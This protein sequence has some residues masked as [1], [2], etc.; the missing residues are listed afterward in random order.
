MN[1]RLSLSL[2]LAAL[3]ATLASSCV[4]DGGRSDI[5]NVIP[6]PQ[7]VRLLGG[8]SDAG[9]C[10][11]KDVTDS[12][13]SE[14]EYRLRIKNGILT[15]TASSE[16]GFLY[17]GQ[18]LR[19]LRDSDGMYPDVEIRDWP[20]FRYRGM[21][22]DCARHFF[23]V[24][25]VKRYLDIMALHKL[26]VLHWHLTDDQGWRI[27]IKSWPRLTEVGAWR[28]GDRLGRAGT[29]IGPDDKPYGGFYTQDEL[30]SIVSYAAGLGIDIMPEIDL[31]GHTLAAL[32]SYP[33]LGCT[34]GPY[35]VWAYGGISQDVLCAGSETTFGFIEDVLTEVMDIFPYEYIHIGGDEC[36]KSRWAGCPRCQSRIKELGLVPDGER[37]AEQALQGYVTERVARFLGEHGRR[38]VGW[39]EI[40]E[41]KAPDDAVVMS[42]RG[43]EGGIKASSL[44]HDV[45]MTPNTNLYFDYCQSWD[46][47]TEPEGIGGFIPVWKVY[48]YEPFTPEM[49][50]SRRLRILGVQANLW[51][52][53]ISSDRH[54]EYMLL[55]RLSALS[56]VQWCEPRR[57]SFDRFMKD[58]ARMSSVYDE[59]GFNYARHIFGIIDQPRS[60]DEGVEFTL[61]TAGDGEI[62]YTLGGSDPTEESPLYTAPFIVAERPAVIKAAAFR[63]GGRS[64]VYSK[65]ILANK[66]FRRKVTAL[67]QKAWNYRW[68]P[69]SSL[70]DGLCGGLSFNTADYAA[71]NEEPMD[72]VIDLASQSSSSSSRSLSSS[73]RPASDS[74]SRSLWFDKLT[75][76]SLSSSKRPHPT[77]VPEYSSVTLCVLVDK[78]NYIF[79]PS[80][81]EVSVSDDG[82]SF[83][84]VAS[85]DVETD[86]K[87]APDGL[88]EIPIYFPESSSRFIRVKASPL[89]PIPDWHPGR[90]HTAFVF[91]DEV[92]VL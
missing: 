18:T 77:T 85:L 80:S 37:T 28:K 65:E 30:R 60:L 68:Q 87:D 23:S 40:L 62:R 73:K 70:V 48:E 75:N 54:L 61:H 7:E 50:D 9:S 71:W 38:M 83:V 67:T 56:E 3:A 31:P 88:R 11:R 14:E 43:S 89:S 79:A 63:D 51:T 46:P 39:D 21:H 19:Q 91:A 4:R 41:G 90:G 64:E 25:E 16:R 49:T 76:R 22:L 35:E 15:V 69:D 45:I 53:F 1:I 5:V 20:R 42:W 57:K 55:P 47:T 29:D 86:T 36:P 82:V 33:D 78:L 81:V 8:R 2:C 34:G 44:G 84:P 17:A 72:V 6:E 66:A 92:I 26:N 74:S 59:M 58:I 24:D 13:L 10:V 12:T 27:E 32:A 52:E